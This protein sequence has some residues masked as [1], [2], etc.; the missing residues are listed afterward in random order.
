MNKKNGYSHYIVLECKSTE[1]DGKYC[2]N[3]CKKQG[4]SHEVDVRAILAFEEIGRGHNAMTTFSKIMKMLAPPKRSNFTKIQNKKILPVV[5]Q[6]ASDSMVSN[7]MDVREQNANDAGEYRVSID[8]TWQKRGHASHNGVVTVILLD[9]KR[10]LDVEVMS[11]KCSQCLKWSKKTNDP[12]YEKWKAS[13][14][15]KI[16]HEGN[17]NSMETASAV[18]TYECLVSTRGLKYRDVLGDRDSSTYNNIVARQPYGEECV[19]NKMEC[20]GHVRKRVGSRLRRLKNQNKGVKLADGKG[21]ASKGRLTDGKIDGFQNYYGLA[22]RENL[23]DVDK[24]VKAI[25]ASLYHVASTDGDP[26][27]DLCPGGENSWCRYKRDKD[28]Y[29]A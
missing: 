26:Q 2:F 25:E 10:C 19:P 6:L 17:A 20:I 16:N 8:L 13:N 14:N 18:R 22:V 1:C 5:K 11:D 9:S 4:H 28:T 15:C 12:R 29:K 7:A 23:N 24:M 21:L 3:S 27:H